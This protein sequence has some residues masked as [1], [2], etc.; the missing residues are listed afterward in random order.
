MGDEGFDLDGLLLLPIE[1][2]KDNAAFVRCGWFHTY[3]LIRQ[4]LQ[5]GGDNCLAK[6]QYILA[7][8]LL[9]WRV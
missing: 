4:S 6:N 5:I 1:N 9:V 2:V 8:E 7:G 3:N